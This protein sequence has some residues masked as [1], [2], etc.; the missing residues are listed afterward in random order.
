MFDAPLPDISEAAA[1]S[2]SVRT[3]CLIGIERTG[4]ANLPD[5]TGRTL[6][7]LAEVGADALVMSQSSAAGSC[8]LAIPLPF[9]FSALDALRRELDAELEQRLVLR[10]WARTDVLL[11]RLPLPGCSLNEVA[12]FCDRLAAAGLNILTMQGSAGGASLVIETSD[13]A[14]VLRALRDEG[15]AQAMAV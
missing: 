4:V 14:R 5:L 3:V 11:L 8:C 9:V 7:A 10:L 2:L 15:F 13:A 1:E 6:L 12:A